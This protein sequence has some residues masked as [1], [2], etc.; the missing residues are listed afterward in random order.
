M[1][2]CLNEL[3]ESYKETFALDVKKNIK[4][5][6][7][8]NV[9]A[10]LLLVPFVFGA[11]SVFRNSGADLSQFT[12]VHK[13]VLLVGLILYILLHEVVHGICFFIFSKKKPVFGFNFLAAWAGAPDYYFHKG[14]YLITC[15]APL[16]FFSVVFLPLCFCLPLGFRLIAIIL[17]GMNVAG[18][19]GDI[20]VAYKCIRYKKILANDTGFKMTI[21]TEV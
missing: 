19:I 4:A 21:Y 1:K 18:S 12:L 3:P 17:M 16:V 14:Q 20:F 11:I 15:L 13:L 2:K 6:I 8:L 5:A 9:C 7:I 10:V